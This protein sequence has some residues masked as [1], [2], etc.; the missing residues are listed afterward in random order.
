MEFNGRDREKKNI[1]IFD[2]QTGIHANC[3]SFSLQ[4]RIKW[5]RNTAVFT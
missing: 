1:A 5:Y 3:A 2:G 4:S